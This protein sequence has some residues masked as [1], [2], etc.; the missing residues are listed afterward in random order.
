MAILPFPT[1]PEADEEEAEEYE[2][3]DDRAALALLLLEQEASV[4]A[5]RAQHAAAGA[6]LD[7][8]EQHLVQLRDQIL[9]LP[10]DDG[11]TDP[12]PGLP[13]AVGDEVGLSLL[14]RVS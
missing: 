13:L 10:D 8:L 3:N 6:R 14:R 1:R 5:M 12:G 4:A 2:P 11:G 9:S 7:A